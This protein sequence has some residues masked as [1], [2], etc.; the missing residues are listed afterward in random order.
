MKEV[1]MGTTGI[2]VPRALP[3]WLRKTGGPEQ[4]V[5]DL[6]RRHR[7]ELASAQAQVANANQRTDALAAAT[8]LTVF[9]KRA[10]LSPEEYRPLADLLTG[11]GIE[12]IT[13]VAEPVDEV[14]EESADIVEWVPHDG[15]PDLG[16]HVSEAFE[17]EIRLDGR[18]VHR[19]KLCCMRAAEPDMAQAAIDGLVPPP[20]PAAPEQPTEFVEALELV[21]D[22]ELSEP[23]EPA[24]FGEDPGPVEPAE[25][26]DPPAGPVDLAESSGQLEPVAAPAATL[27]LPAGPPPA[28]SMDQQHRWSGGLRRIWAAVTGRVPATSTQDQGEN[29]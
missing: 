6:L 9:K 24:E 5:A 13:Y 4:A 2:P 21:G 7:T 14:L 10:A 19:A 8:A 17:P 18:P 29:E 16:E 26:P 28:T 15:G 20:E 25:V 3:S 23:P 27:D 1:T 12:V 11:Q 22:P